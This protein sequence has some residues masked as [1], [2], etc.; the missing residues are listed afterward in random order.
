MLHQDG[1]PAQ[2]HAPTTGLVVHLNA[3]LPPALRGLVR[4]QRGLVEL[5]RP[6]RAQAAVR[7]TRDWHVLYLWFVRTVFS[8]NGRSALLPPPPWSLPRR[9]PLVP[10][11]W[12][13]ADPAPRGKEAGE[14][15]V[16]PTAAR[17]GSIPMLSAAGGNDAAARHPF[18]L[19]RDGRGGGAEA[20]EGRAREH[21]QEVDAAPPWGE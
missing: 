7:A 3:Q 14:E 19:G 5:R 4:E 17:G 13:L 16:M 8:G 21:H 12:V 11:T 6:V 9:A 18:Q 20:E 15:V 2:S 1:L 10:R